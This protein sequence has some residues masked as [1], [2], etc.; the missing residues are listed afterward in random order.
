MHPAATTGCALLLFTMA[1][2]VLSNSP[3]SHA[4]QNILEAPVGIQAGPFEFSRLLPEWINDVLMTYFF[5][6][7]RELKRELVLGGLRNTLP[8]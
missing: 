6:V 7:S 5:L 2:L 4:F 3:W 8:I 1:A